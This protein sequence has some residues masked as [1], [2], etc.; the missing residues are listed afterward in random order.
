MASLEA[1]QIQLLA[2]SNADGLSHDAIASLGRL[3]ESLNRPEKRLEDVL[4]TFDP[5][6]RIELEKLRRMKKSIENGPFLD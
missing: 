5:K 4:A 3:A 6:D 1:V 2:A